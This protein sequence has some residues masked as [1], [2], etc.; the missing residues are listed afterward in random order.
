MW[1]E[2]DVSLLPSVARS[3]LTLEVGPIAHSTA[4]SRLYK[5]TRAVLFDLLSLLETHNH[6]YQNPGVYSPIMVRV[7]RIH[8]VLG[9][10]RNDKGELNGLI[11]E[12]VHGIPEAKADSFVTD[13]TPLFELFT[14]EVLTLRNCERHCRLQRLRPETDVVL[15][16]T[17]CNEAAYYEKDIAMYLSTHVSIQTLG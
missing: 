11:H 4:V 1:S 8:T 2:G 7:F 6:S 16:P 12:D 9:F 14:G 15:Y 13:D 10:P 3:G 5:L 17:F